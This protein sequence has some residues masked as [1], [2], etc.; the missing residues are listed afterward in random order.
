M[1]SST[2]T[3][4]GQAAPSHEQIADW[5]DERQGR[6]IGIANMSTNDEFKF[7][8]GNDWDNSANNKHRWYAV[9]NANGGKM[10][11]DPGAGYDNFKWTGANGRVRAIWDGADPLNLQYSLTPATEMRVVGN[12]MVGVNECSTFSICS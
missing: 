12:G 7:H 1:E 6:F 10:V 4:T 2:T 9:D 8:D 11:I 3:P 5:L